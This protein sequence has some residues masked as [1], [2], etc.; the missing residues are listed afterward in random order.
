MAKLPFLLKLMKFFPNFVPAHAITYTNKTLGRALDPHTNGA[1][2][3][4][5]SE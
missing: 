1:W 2:L 5:L 3:T 4:K